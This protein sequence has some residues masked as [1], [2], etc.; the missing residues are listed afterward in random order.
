MKAV[1]AGALI[2][3]NER[4]AV[5]ACAPHFHS[6]DGT[7]ELQGHRHGAAPTLA[8]LSGYVRFDQLALQHRDRD[9]EIVASASQISGKDWVGDIGDIEDTRPL[10]LPM[11]IGIEKLNP[12]TQV[13][14]ERVQFHIGAG[15]VR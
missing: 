7:V 8:N 2:G 11:D 9:Q 1:T 3:D 15:I 5:A 12:P 14:D 10:L 4:K 13:S 6:L